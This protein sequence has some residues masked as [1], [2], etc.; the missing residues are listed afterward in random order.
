MESQLSMAETIA[1]KINESFKRT[2][3]CP[4]EAAVEPFCVAPRVYYV[5]G[6][7]WVASYLIDSG[8]GLILIDTAMQEMLYLVTESIRKLG[9]DPKDIRKI[10]LSHAHMDHC[11]GA[12]PLSEYSGAEIYL[13]REDWEFMHTHREHVFRPPFAVGDFTPHK[14]Y[15]DESPICLGD[16]VINTLHTP[17]H[18][19]GTTSFFFTVPDRNGEEYRVAMH[20][21]LGL[22][23]LSDEYLD[24]VGLPRSLQ[25]SYCLNLRKLREREVDI[26]LPSHPDILENFLE[27]AD[28]ESG[29]FHPFVDISVWPA[30]MDSHLE[31]MEQLLGHKV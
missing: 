20:G 10:L 25:K 15:S 27:L 21:G 18:T 3:Y 4:W 5:G 6:N 9:Y 24:R 2:C 17:G 8:E 28:R 31:M 16:I 7:D 12:R 30:L 26:T 1:K 14:F 19:P 29:D 22:N 11:G 23:S 13:A